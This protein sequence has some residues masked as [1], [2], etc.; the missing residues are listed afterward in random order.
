[1]ETFLTFVRAFVCGGVL[2]LIGQILI[3]RTRLTPAR[4]LT[5]YVVAGVVLGAVGLYEPVAEWGGA[6]ATVPLLGFG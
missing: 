4:I 6:G 5:L 2:C 1:M 3:D